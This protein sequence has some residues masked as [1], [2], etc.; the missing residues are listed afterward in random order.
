MKNKLLIIF[1]LILGTHA[2][3]SQV[4]ITGVV[5][6]ANQTPLPGVS[7]VEKGTT[8][9]VATNFDG[10]YEIEDSTNNAIL[11]FS[12]IGMKSR[13]ISINNQS[14]VN[15]TLD[16]DAAQLDEVVIVGYGTQKK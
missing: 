2:T 1:S 9:G 4:K 13:E 3:W 14:V 8:N 15:I 11:L 12:F 16:D 10:N 5:L 6:D 7:V